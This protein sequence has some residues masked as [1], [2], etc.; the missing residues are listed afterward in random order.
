MPR[1]WTADDEKLAAELN[2]KLFRRPFTLKHLREWLD[3]IGV[4]GSSETEEIELAD[5][6]F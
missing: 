2:I 6:L 1:K 3:Q 4:A 5:E